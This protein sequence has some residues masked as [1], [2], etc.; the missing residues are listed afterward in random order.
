MKRNRTKHFH[1]WLVLLLLTAIIFLYSGAALIAGEKEEEPAMVGE[2]PVA[3]KRIG[4]IN[5]GNQS[6]YQIAHSEWFKKF[7]EEEGAKVTVIDGKMDPTVQIKALED[8]VAMGVDGIIIQPFDVVAVSPAIK[9]VRNAGIPV[10]YIGSLP[11][12]SAVIPAG[13]VYNDD[14]LVKEA[15]QEAVA[16]LKKNKPG[17]K[18][19]LVLFDYPMIV[20]CHEWRILPFR[21]EFVKLMGKDMVD[22]VYHE[23]TEHTIE[24]CV[25]VMED[26][27]QSG[28]DF[29][30][31]LACGGTGA[32]GGMQA[33]EAAGLAKAVNG[34]PQDVWVLTI[35]ATPTEL[36]YLV[37]PNSSVA[38]TIALTPKTNARVFLDNFKKILT[39]EIDPDSNYVANAPGVL[40]WKKYGCE[41][42]S[43]ILADQYAVVPGYSS[44]KCK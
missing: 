32:V 38:A 14:V 20:I 5:F 1:Q 4:Y 41:K 3:G 34:V 29:N 36:E 27:I 37:D 25:R 26:I 23:Y 28:R 21:D 13:G 40:L 8:M 19:K 18:A 30:I 16:W 31:F 12:P 11:D 22:I 6:E 39:G 2:S 43:D 17:E 7:A 42:I 24:N 35:D 9:E 44:L 15:A 33:L 10:M